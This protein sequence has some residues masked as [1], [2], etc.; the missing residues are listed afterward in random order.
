MF[1]I[2]QFKDKGRIIL[3]GFLILILGSYMLRNGFLGSNVDWMSQHTVFPDYFRR[4]FYETGDLLPNFAANIGAGQNIYNFSYY[5][6]LNPVIMIS[7]LFPHV[8]M[9]A[10]IMAT[11]I[12][13]LAAACLIFY[14]WLKNKGFS[15]F[16]TI[17]VSMI[18]VLASPMLYHS[19][20][21][22]IFVNYLPF[23][24]LAFFAVDRYFN[25]G[26]RGLLTVSVFSLIMSSFYYSVS[27]LFAITLYG[28]SVYLEKSNHFQIRD[29]LRSG[30]RFLLPIITA[31]LMAGLLLV[32][33]FAS[34]LE[35]QR[36]ERVAIS[37]YSLLLPNFKLLRYLY[38][39]YGL[40]LSSI[41]ITV[42]T[43]SLFYKKRSE[44]FLAF[45]LALFT[46]FPVFLYALNGG[47][48][49]EDKALIPFLPLVCYLMALFFQKLDN[50]DH[51]LRSKLMYLFPITIVLTLVSLGQTIYWL[52][53][54]ADA[55]LMF[56]CYMVYRNKNTVKLFAIPVIMILLITDFTIQTPGKL[57]GKDIYS[58]IFDPDISI[59]MQKVNHAD[60]SFYR[61]DSLVNKDNDLNRTYTEHQYLTSF[62]SSSYQKDYF[63]FRNDIF[64]LERPYRN[65]LM[66]P[67]S[68]NPLF[69]SFMGV[70]YVY[71]DNAPA[72]YDNYLEKDR[73]KIYQNQNSF[74]LGY[75]TDQLISEKELSQ[76]DFPYRQEL[77]MHRAAI[78]KLPS[79][80]EVFQTRISPV[81][82]RLAEQKGKAFKLT[83]SNGTYRISAKKVAFHSISLPRAASEDQVVFLEMK[84]KNLTPLQDI[85][86]AIQ[87]EQN[88]LSAVAQGYHY[89]NQNNIFRY[90][91]T[92]KKGSQSLAIKFSPGEYEISDLKSYTLNTADM[93]DSNL[94]ASPYNVSAKDTKG[95]V[96]SGS[97]IAK[98]DGY[99]ITSIP[100][101]KNFKVTM[102][103]KSISYEEV[104]TAFVGF[105]ISK[106]VHHIIFR[107]ESPGFYPGAVSSV[108]GFSILGFLI[109]TDQK[110]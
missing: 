58:E 33:T 43:A 47:L 62:Y 17:S 73:T 69:L 103:G 55:T 102:D 110:K 81:T 34:L 32:P 38:S 29:F 79:R 97:V 37:I 51:M 67:A 70:K 59:A 22:I 66:Q 1:P 64:Q 109:F 42:L 98:K 49:I 39:P 23:L 35:S 96:I 78:N 30:A 74:P 85:S 2:S 7:Y 27:G 44:K 89:S 72:G 4:L 24:C 36:G 77:L 107:Y 94:T 100:Y 93:F 3:I 57:V 19:Y 9:P 21:Q 68:Q 101:D 13:S 31:V 48:Y 63:D 60:P 45:G 106:G 71:A 14:Q 18:F 46:I 76:V 12:L 16:I 40:G 108:I 11:S 54:F 20:K 25:T 95:D 26:K 87:N 80:E 104:N 61:M 10:Y 56:L 90:A 88:K 65:Y 41:V 105:P 8:E 50:R 86:I 52:L 53:A 82:L 6:L 92:V 28:F 15:Y 84:V 91:V 83:L 5:G 75:A 99:F